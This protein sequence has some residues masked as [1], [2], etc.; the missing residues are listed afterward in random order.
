MKY[1]Y[2]DEIGIIDVIQFVPKLENSQVKHLSIGFIISGIKDIDG[3]DCCVKLQ[4]GELYYI[5]R[6]SYQTSCTPIGI[7]P[8]EEIVIDYDESEAR[9]LYAIVSDMRGK[10]RH[11]YKHKLVSSVD[12]IP[13]NNNHNIMTLLNRLR[14]STIGRFAGQNYKTFKTNKVKL[15]R[16]LLQSSDCDQLIA[17]IEEANKLLI[18]I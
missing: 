15:V 7:Y 18:M 3:I 6:G 12:V 8:F 2:N 5:S 13:H 4:A 9:E 11:R 1:K 14:D 10:H 17:A 16:F